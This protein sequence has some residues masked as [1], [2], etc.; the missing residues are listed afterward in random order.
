MNIER[1]SDFAVKYAMQSR[2]I[3]V[4]NEA[5]IPVYYNPTAS[6]NALFTMREN[7]ILNLSDQGMNEALEN[8]RNNGEGRFSARIGGEYRKRFEVLVTR[9]QSAFVFTF[10]QI[11]DEST[12][13]QM[14]TEERMLIG[15][16]YML[17][18]S[19]HNIFAT[20][21][22]MQYSDSVDIK[23][24]GISLRRS[25]LQ[26]IR[27]AKQ[28]QILNEEPICSVLN[29][30]YLVQYICKKTDAFLQ[31]HYDRRLVIDI[32]PKNISV[33]CDARKVRFILLSLI[34]NAVRFGEGDII[35]QLTA[36]RDMALLIVHN[37]G[38]KGMRYSI[39][40]HE[41]GFG[42]TF[43]ENRNDSGAG[44]GLATSR[45]LAFK[46]QGTLLVQSGESST[47]ISVAFPLAQTETYLNESAT[48]QLLDENFSV[49]DM[50]FSS[51]D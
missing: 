2:P 50:E 36:T 46:M 42:K 5:L 14:S 20:S 34:S 47:R 43:T 9:D 48:E 3:I 1:F 33:K 29:F 39:V 24:V 26:S 18:N 12:Q 49:L 4:T 13:Q 22:M 10:I 21:E 11:A 16:E 44:L 23:K 25:C 40:G 41:I 19:L 38:K 27:I 28:V 15:Y 31:K 32:A 35:V 17:G 30:R 45:Q 6:E 51:I 8:C 7:F 37:R